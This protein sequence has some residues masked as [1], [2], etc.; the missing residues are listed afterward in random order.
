VRVQGQQT[1]ATVE[2]FMTGH[3]GSI[4]GGVASWSDQSFPVTVALKNGQTVTATQK[5]G[6]DTSQP[7]PG[8]S[9]QKKPPSLGGV[10]FQSHIYECGR[11]VWLIGAFPGATV[12]LTVLGS[13]R[14][15][16]VSP[17][18]NA[19]I[20]LTQQLGPSD[21]LVARQ[22]GCGL[23]PGVTISGP[24]PDPA[25]VN[26]KRQVPAPSLPGP[27][28]QCDPAVLVTDV[29]EGSTVTLTRSAGPTESAC[30]DATGLWFVLSTPLVLGETVTAVQ[31]YSN[32]D[33]QGVPTLPVT[34]GPV[35]VEPPVVS[36]PLCAGQ[37]T[38]TVTDYKPGSII[39]IFQNGVS[40]GTGQAPE[41]PSFPFGVPPLVGGDVITARQTRCGKTSVDSNAVPVDPAPKSMPTPVVPG[42]L[43]ECASVVRVENLHIGARV[44]VFSTLL[45]A[46]IGDAQVFDTT[47]DVPVAPLLILGDK[48]VAR[49]IGCGQTSHDSTPPQT[50][51]SAPTLKAPQVVPPLD[52]C[53][54][55]VPVDQVEPGAL[56]DVYVNN[57][58][59]GTAAAGRRP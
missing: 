49:Q 56:V 28:E 32:C 57:L 38:V 19:R 45:A 22:T 2:I 42:P 13:P 39:E 51:G 5:L 33:V 44:Y 50:V 58:P 41:E 40:L 35:K 18:G 23:P 31:N 43:V 14:G 26:A 11:C 30:F 17:D 21:I 47:V 24:K 48:V 20:G 46:E 4:G 29:F 55:A 15:S 16:T 6:S 52:D 1:G 7:G 25:P 12:S 27:L 34:V 53:M 8:I 10:T 36:E 59:R 54:S 9:V 37:T 3:S